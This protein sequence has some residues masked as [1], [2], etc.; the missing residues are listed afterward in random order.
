MNEIVKIHNDLTN[1][2]LGKMTSKE[3]DLFMCVCHK[4]RDKGTD[5]VVIGFDELRKLGN[6]SAT[7]N[8]SL[9]QDIIKANSKLLEFQFIIEKGAKT[10]QRTL[11]K[12]FITDADECTVTVSVWEE[13]M[14]ILNDIASNFTRFELSEFVSIESKYAKRLYKLLKQYRTQGTYYTNKNDFYNDLNVPDTYTNTNFNKKILRPAIEEC[15]RYMPKLEC[16]PKKFGRGG[17][18]QG[19]TFIFD[20]EI[21]EQALKVKGKNKRNTFNKF[22]QTNIDFDE[23]EKNILSN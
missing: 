16:I 9:K 20:R 14:Y 11:F 21:P 18:V 2:K 6:Y 19:Y 4:M 23:L 22:E 15:K 10:Y 8:K 1:E 17:A 5:E 7:S 12:N 3:L 13:T